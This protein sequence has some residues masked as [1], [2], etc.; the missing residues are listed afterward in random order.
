MYRAE[1]KRRKE[2]ESRIAA[3]REAFKQTRREIRG[4]AEARISRLHSDAESLE[5]YNRLH[6]YIKSVENEVEK[7]PSTAEGYFQMITWIDWANEYVKTI[8]PFRNGLP[9]FE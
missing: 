6:E 4:K 9:R 8:H 2:E 3:I 1:W 5:E 7:I